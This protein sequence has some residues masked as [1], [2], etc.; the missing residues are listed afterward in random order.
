MAVVA[1]CT[2][3]MQRVSY[4]I[5]IILE[6]IFIFNTMIL[7]ISA[8]CADGSIRATP[9]TVT[10]FPNHSPPLDLLG[11]V[12][13]ITGILG[14]LLRIS[15][16]R[17]LGVGFTYDIPKSAAPKLAT[18]GPYSIVRHP[19]YL[20]L[21]LISFG[22]PLYHLSPGSWISESGFLEWKIA[23]GSGT[24]DLHL[25]WTFPLGRT[26][27]YL[28]VAAAVA[29]PLLLSMRVSEEDALMKEQ[30]GSKWDLW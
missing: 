17:A 6:S 3:P 1:G 18:T 28:W 22:L 26:L 2:F 20:A 10:L 29:A 5:A 9:S 13:L 19:S 12:G 30:F 11:I 14:C 4:V 8:P 24:D 27:V 15:C 21:W 25:G 7:Q 23:F 16:Y